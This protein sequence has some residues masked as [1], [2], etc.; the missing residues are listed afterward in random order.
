MGWTRHSVL[1]VWVL[2]LEIGK[3]RVVFEDSLNEIKSKKFAI[4]IVGR[5][6]DGLNDEDRQ[7]VLGAIERQAG[8][9][10]LY[11]AARNYTYTGSENSWYRHWQG[12]CGCSRAN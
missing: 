6:I 5:W 10:I 8:L 11:R 9:T 2:G 12:A 7:Q 1:R 3:V 4:C